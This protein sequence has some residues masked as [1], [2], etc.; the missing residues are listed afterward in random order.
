M[1]KELT[2]TRILYRTICSVEYTACKL[3][4]ELHDAK[5]HVQLASR[6]VCCILYASFSRSQKFESELKHDRAEP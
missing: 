6:A 5:Y 2:F 1:Q 4:Q 3:L